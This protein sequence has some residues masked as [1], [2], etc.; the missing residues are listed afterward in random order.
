MGDFIF[1][2][3]FVLTAQQGHVLT[4]SPGQVG[5]Y[6]APSPW[7]LP[8]CSAALTAPQLWLHPG[9]CGAPWRRS[10]LLSHPWRW[11]AAWCSN[12]CGWGEETDDL[13]NITIWNV[14]LSLVLKYLILHFQHCI[15]QRSC[16]CGVERITLT[17]RDSGNSASKCRL[18]TFGSQPPSYPGTGWRNTELGDRRWW[19]MGWV[20]QRPHGKGWNVLKW[21]ISQG[22]PSNLPSRLVVWRSGSSLRETSTKPR[23]LGEE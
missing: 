18:C 1:I 21:R 7:T 17:G 12:E 3:F 10:S 6:T 23:F 15:P 19:M 14:C 13:N 11:A 16:H 5:S 4:S 22:K 9:R 2:L 8:G 20:K